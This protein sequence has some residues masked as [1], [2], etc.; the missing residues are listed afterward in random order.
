MCRYPSSRFSIVCFGLVASLAGSPVLAGLIELDLTGNEVNEL[1]IRS[2]VRGPAMRNLKRL[3]LGNNPLREGIV[4]LVQSELFGRMIAGDSRLDLHR[5]GIELAGVEALASSATLGSVTG[6]NLN[7]NYLGDAGVRAL[8]RSGRLENVRTLRLARNQI[9]DAGAIALVAA[10]LP[11]LKRL[12]LA[13]NRLTRRGVDALKAAAAARG[14]AVEA[15]NNGTEPT[16][17]LPT[18]PARTEA[19]QFAELKRRIAHPARPRS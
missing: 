16:A 2:L 17:A 18:S 3:R 15:A 5:C 12:E 6:L 13:N 1:A 11:R 8:C 4:E 10:S 7:E 19:I 14:F 9:A